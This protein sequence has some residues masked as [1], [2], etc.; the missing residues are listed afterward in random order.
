MAGGVDHRPVGRGGR[1]VRGAA[2]A[3]DVAAGVRLA[4]A[5]RDFD[6]RR[7][8]TQALDRGRAI[9]VS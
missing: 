7:A 5:A 3:L 2:A 4:A 9:V 8:P 6:G 1:R